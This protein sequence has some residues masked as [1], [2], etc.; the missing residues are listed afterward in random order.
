[1]IGLVVP[2]LTVNLGSVL[3]DNLTVRWPG[4]VLVMAKDWRGL[5]AD[6]IIKELS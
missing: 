2:I 5:R 3:I 6:D 1:M 4:P